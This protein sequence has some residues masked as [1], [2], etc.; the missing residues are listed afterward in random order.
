MPRPSPHGSAAHPDVVYAERSRPV[1][2]ERIP[3][4]PRYANQFYL[5]PG[6]TT[7]DAQSAWDL[8]T[9]SP[10]VVVAVLDTGYTNHADLAGRLLPGYD[11]VANFALSNDG[12]AKDAAGNYRDADAVRPRRLGQHRRPC[13]ARSQCALH[14]SAKARGMARR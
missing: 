12:N 14:G 3:N 10:A 9:G 11:F 5:L 2:A 4:D 6:A 1:R 8:T 13:P 7:I